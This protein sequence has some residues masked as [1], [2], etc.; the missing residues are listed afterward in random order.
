MSFACFY[1][2]I[3]VLIGIKR[4][5]AEFLRETPKRQWPWSQHTTE[6]VFRVIAMVA[7]GMGVLALR[8]FFLGT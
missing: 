6:W 4:D 3:R 8:R 2:G 1:I 5:A 7:F